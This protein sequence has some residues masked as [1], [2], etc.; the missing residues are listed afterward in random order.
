M[1]HNDHRTS[2]SSSK[3]SFLCAMIIIP[4]ISSG[5]QLVGLPILV[6]HPRGLTKRV[7]AVSLPYLPTPPLSSVRIVSS[8]SPSNCSFQFFFQPVS[9]I[10]S[11]C[12]LFQISCSFSLVY[13][14]PATL[15]LSFLYK[16]N[17][18]SM[19]TSIVSPSRTRLISVT[20]K[21]YKQIIMSYC[22]V[23]SLLP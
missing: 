14:L 12:L 18:R 5:D 13:Q 4:C 19:V 3:S 7:Q 15:T 20:L 8:S 23:N 22:S 9:G 1:C 2:R 11:Q 6:H 16:S 10:Y 21:L 17:P